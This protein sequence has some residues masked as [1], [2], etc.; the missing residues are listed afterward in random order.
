MQTH[1]KLAMCRLGR[2]GLKSKRV[3]RDGLHA[4]KL[5]ALSVLPMIVVRL[6]RMKFYAFI[7]SYPGFFVKYEFGTFLFQFGMVLPQQREQPGNIGVFIPLPPDGHPV[8]RVPARLILLR[9][10]QEDQ[11]RVVPV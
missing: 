4:Q 8:E 11:S 5:H 7:I 1:S 9:Q 3:D 10:R 6:P 2:H